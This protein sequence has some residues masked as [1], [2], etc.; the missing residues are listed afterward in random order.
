M[1]QAAT[2]RAAE[3]R[4]RE[5]EQRCAVRWPAASACRPE[6]GVPSR[7]CRPGM[8]VCGFRGP[9]GRRCRPEAGA[10]RR[11][12]RAA[13]WRGVVADLRSACR[14]EV[15]VPSRFC[16]V[17]PLGETRRRSP[18]GLRCR[19][20][21]RRSQPSPLRPPEP[22]TTRSRASSGRCPRAVRPGPSRSPGWRA[23]SRP[24]RP[25]ARPLALR[26]PAPRRVRAARSSGSWC[27][28]GRSGRRVPGCF[29]GAPPHSTRRR[30]SWPARRRRRRSAPP[31]D[32]RPHPAARSRAPRGHRRFPRA[33]PG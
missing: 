20:E 2:A 8:A 15:G 22:S 4:N 9:L 3:A 25:A 14:P 5:D 10:P 29:R 13:E 31:G 6:A 16:R 32:R 11:K 19:T 27:G 28:G 7:F 21:D 24:P 17:W 1:P 18:C 26:R 30:F 12:R 33:P 23:R